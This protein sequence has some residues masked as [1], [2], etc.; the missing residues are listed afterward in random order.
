M[1]TTGSV[2]AAPPPAEVGAQADGAEAPPKRGRGRPPGSKNKVGGAAAVK[3]GAGQGQ[4][5]PAGQALPGTSSSS[6]MQKRGRGR[7]RKNDL[8]VVEI[9]D[10]EPDAGPRLPTQAAMGR[11]LVGRRV[12][13][14]F[15][16]S[17][18]FEGEVMKYAADS[19]S[20]TV[21]YDDGDCEKL[22][23]KEVLLILQHAP[24]VER[25]VT[26]PIASA[27]AGIV[28]LSPSKLTAKSSTLCGRGCEGED[29]EA[30]HWC[31]TCGLPICGFC[32][33]AH[34]RQAKTREHVLTEIAVGTCARPASTHTDSL[35][36]DPKDATPRPLAGKTN[37]KEAEKSPDDRDEE[38]EDGDNEEEDGSNDYCEV[39]GGGGELVCCDFCE[40]AYHGPKCLNAKAEDLPEPYKCPKCSGTLEAVKLDY[41]QRKKARRDKKRA[42]REDEGKNDDK[43]GKRKKILR[44][45]DSSDEMQDA[46]DE[47][48]H[49]VDDESDDNEDDDDDDDFGSDADL[50]VKRKPL[51]VTGRQRLTRGMREALGEPL[52]AQRRLKR[53]QDSDSGPASSSEDDVVSD[54]S[55]DSNRADDEEQDGSPSKGPKRKRIRTVNKLEKH[56]LEGA[57]EGKL[58]E[59]KRDKLRHEAAS[60]VGKPLVLMAPPAREGEKEREIHVPEHMAVQ[61]Q[62][63]QR[64]GVAFL[65][66]CVVRNGKGAILAHCMGLGKTF[67]ALTIL[68]CIWQ[69]SLQ[70]H[71]TVQQHK[72]LVLAP[73]NVIRNWEDELAK[74]MPD[75]DSPPVFTMMNAGARHEDRADYLDDW[76]KEGGIMLMGYDQF[77]NMSTGR[78]IRNGKKNARIKERYANALIKP[79]PYLVVCDEGHILRRETSGVTKAVRSIETMRRVV[80]SG[81]PLQNNLM[82]YHTMVDIVR[83]DVLGNANSFKRNFV[84]PILNGQCIDSTDSDVKLMKYRSHILH[85]TLKG[86][87]DRADFKVLQP[88]LRPKH[89][90]VIGIRLSALQVKLY[91]AILAQNAS[92]DGSGMGLRVLSTYQQLAKVW[93]H[94]RVLLM[95][96]DDK[97]YD[98]ME[99]FIDDDSEGVSWSDEEERRKKKEKQRE[100][101]KSNTSVSE[102][103]ESDVEVAGDWLDE[104]REELEQMAADSMGKLLFLCRL[105]KEAGEAGEKVLCF[106]QSLLVLDLIEIMLSGSKKSEAA[107]VDGN[108]RKRKWHNGIDYFRL[109]GSTHSDRRKRE[110]DKFNKSKKA[111]LYL[112]STRAGSLGVNLVSANRVVIMDASWN[113][114]YDTQAIFR[115]YRFGQEK[116]CY[117]YRLLAHGTME[118]K[119]YGRQVTKIALSSRV[120]DSEETGRHFSQEELTTLFEFSPEP[121]AEVVGEEQAALEAVRLKKQEEE[122]CKMVDLEELSKKKTGLDSGLDLSAEAPA[123]PV[124]NPPTADTISTGE[125]NR[126]EGTKE[127]NNPNLFAMKALPP[128]DSVLARV[129]ADIM[130]KW[131]VGYHESDS[132]NE[133]ETELSPE[134]IALAW[135]EWEQ[136]ESRP[137][138]PLASARTITIRLPD[139]HG[140]FY[141]KLVP[142]SSP[143]GQSHLFAYQKELIL[144]WKVWHDDKSGRAYYQDLR[145]Q[146]VQW[147]PPDWWPGTDQTDGY[148]IKPESVPEMQRWAC[149]RD[150]ACLCL[151]AFVLV[152]RARACVLFGTG[153]SL[154]VLHICACSEYFLSDGNGV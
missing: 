122:T 93:T 63:H 128:K 60:Q 66:D 148:G 34:R 144:C 44:L 64:V 147:N 98:S 107:L 143:D 149:E 82:E 145:T 62:P 102:D 136:R 96:K 14:L 43:A 112:I 28:S 124:D 109:D 133:V 104:C 90:F 68:Q 119:I 51:V 141:S 12:R 38:R 139:G 88:Y 105:L 2:H 153:F 50:E 116:D 9:E 72:I 67:Q 114:S 26:S 13:K 18:W 151:Y 48:E 49:D 4:G 16:R 125:E 10:D 132:L 118:Q 150:G 121:T 115:A 92:P 113:P 85:S 95:Q 140:G 73:V 47:S 25:G 71:T 94:P 138:A 32:V 154:V 58:A 52:I 31:E 55:A 81:T 111:R 89:E 54:S 11:A 19:D 56:I 20:Y 59:A 84:A 103:E 1:Q 27:S 39:C 108:G 76:V 87:V 100:K 6:G 30:T 29:A 35:P 101:K 137:I 36:V 146:Q 75:E 53:A 99:N 126:D 21:T 3:A 135:K 91:K 78:G 5:A 134:E 8:R 45:E 123:A 70:Q 22:E 110:I 33:T 37:A 69:E 40:C 23:L 7:P 86:V 120:V 74:W 97:G 83:P 152:L 131:I 77:R 17:G 57:Q 41:E 79:G 15:P 106:S 61:L 65:W 130:P 127:T 80:L 142:I 117:I 42:T 129:L 24:E 46:D